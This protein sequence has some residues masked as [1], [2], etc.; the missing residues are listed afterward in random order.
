MGKSFLKELSELV[1]QQVISHDT[2]ERIRQHYSK[3]QQPD[4]PSRIVIIF[5]ILGALLTGLGIIL[6]IAHNWDQF[7][8]T[9]KLGVAFLPLLISQALCAYALIKKKESRVWREAT[10]VLLI[11]SIAA[12]ISIT[13]QVY[14][15]HGSLDRFL[16]AWMLLSVPVMY[17]MQ[18]G[19]A[20]ILVIVGITWYGVVSSTAR[21]SLHISWN[22]W[23]LL[24]AI[25]PFYFLQV[26]KIGKNFFYFSS[27]LIPISAAIC[28]IMFAEQAEE[29]MLITYMSLFCLF[30]LI[31]QTSLLS[32]HKLVT[33]GFLIIGS[34]G[35]IAMLLIGTFDELWREISGALTA[36]DE[37]YAAA[38]VSLLTTV[39]LVMQIVRRGMRTVNPK[40][41]LYLL[42]IGLFFYAPYSPTATQIAANVLLLVIA[43]VT[44]RQGAQDDRL[45]ILNY[46]LLIIAAL[47]TCRFFDTQMTFVLRG[48]LFI[49]VGIG[50]FAANYWMMKRRKETQEA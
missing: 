27:W 11:T 19:M 32:E 14:H 7:A 47:V 26:K 39:L 3:K 18:S 28:L 13:S 43:I 46:G 12:A 36:E 17:I 38:G 23:G 25:L 37:W 15:L 16:L 48:V 10:S 6:I 5:G 42:Y 22:Y 41:Y 2:A 9:H 24:V 45:L 35:T 1:E 30:I 33:N 21:F 34:L 49:A 50:F 29:Y 31:G 40:A 8:K 44:I 20:A 4:S